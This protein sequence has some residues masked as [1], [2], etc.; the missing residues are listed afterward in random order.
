MS[1]ALIALNNADLSAAA[2]A[3]AL[4][5]KNE[6]LDAAALIGRVS[7]AQENSVAVEAQA[8]LADFRRQVE[9][10]RVEAKA[11]ALEF[12]KKIDAAAKALSIEVTEEEARV[13]MLIGNFHQLEEAN[14]KAAEEV[15]RLEAERIEQARIAEE[16]RILRGQAE[17]EVE[18]RRVAA[19]LQKQHDIERA[20]VER[21]AREAKDAES[22]KR[23]EAEAAVQRE[24]HE[25]AAIELARQQ[26]LSN[27]KTHEALDAA[28]ERAC[29]AQAAVVVP[30]AEPIK[31]KGQTL[32]ADIEI[33][34][35]D[36][37]KLYRAHPNC[38]NLTP[39]EGEIKSLIRSG[40]KPQGVKFRE[41]VKAGTRGA[42]TPQAIEV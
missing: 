17:R 26:E 37:H 12:G 19:E 1:D 29:I 38:L 6:A 5:L 15:A 7:N 16:R 23:F 3:Q 40:V 36:V 30:T 41:I 27:A 31:A 35:V 42:R 33:L 22:R 9:K 4:V 28:Q 2:T 24:R 11:P 39:L 32:K 25:R 21:A 20:T 8:K 10:A 13:S 18:A 34:S 14:R